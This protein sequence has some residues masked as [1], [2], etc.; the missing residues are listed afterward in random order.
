MNQDSSSSHLL[1]FFT[2]QP[3]SGLSCPADSY[4]NVTVDLDRYLE[5]NRPST[6]FVRV[7]GKS[8][9]NAG[10]MDQAILV[11]SRDRPPK[12]DDIVIADIDGDNSAEVVAPSMYGAAWFGRVGGIGGV[13]AYGQAD[14]GW[15]PAG[16]SWNAFN[17]AETNYNSDST[18]FGTTAPWQGQNLYQGRPPLVDLGTD[19]SVGISEACFSACESHGEVRVAVQIANEGGEDVDT[20]VQVALYADNEGELELIG[21]QT[22]AGGVSSGRAAEG[23]EFVFSVEQY[24]TDGVVARVDDDGSMTEAYQECEE[25]NNVDTWN[26]SPCD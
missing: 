10:I 7:S 3:P 6:F 17:F 21:V 8:M 9:V 20:D 4:A 13:T 24:G 23:I 14:D 11:A 5:A 1:P 15:A 19:L 12:H 25:D 26:D 18:V 16:P 2:P 22:V